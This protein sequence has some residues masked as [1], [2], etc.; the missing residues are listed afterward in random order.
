MPPGYRIRVLL[1]KRYRVSEILGHGGMG[2]VFRGCDELL[3][4]PVAVKLM[5]P[6]RHD[7]FAAARFRREARAA[8][9]VKDPH[10]V[11]AYDFGRHDGSYYLVMELV[12]GRS[13]AH[14]LALH[15]PLEPERA[16]DVIRQAAA[17]LAAAH[18]RD[19][20]HRDIKP[21]NLLIDADGT[22]KVADF[23]IAR[24]LTDT[25]TSTTAGA[26]LGTSH[27][28]APERAHGKPASAASDVYALGCVLYQLLTGRPPFLGDDPTAVLYQHVTSDPDPPSRLRPELAGPIDALV[29]RMLAKDPAERPTAAE[30]AGDTVPDVPPVE[31]P[32]KRHRRFWRR[33]F[34][35][36]SVVLLVGTAA[37]GSVLTDDGLE[38]PATTRITPS[39]PSP[40]PTIPTVTVTKSVP[41]P[42]ATK[43]ARP[44]DSSGLSSTSSGSGSNEQSKDSG[45]QGKR[46]KQPDKKKKN[47]P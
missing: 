29:L 35:V 16:V 37:T 32:P 40:T 10:V 34:L 42:P 6:D 28:L 9:M 14:E 33:A 45:N 5:L 8:A 4:R 12:E 20:V 23:G 7:P 36:S 44:P 39:R 31:P 26:V 47:K 3:G 22:V 41:P 21:S 25:T 38:P 15:G 13:V 27:Y 30:I 19:I 17:G 11:A 2:E 43:S 18:R 46:G 24:F 1:A